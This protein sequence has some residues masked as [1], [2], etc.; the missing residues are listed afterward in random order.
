MASRSRKG[1][2]EVAPLFLKPTWQVENATSSRSQTEYRE[3]DQFAERQG[4][5]RFQFLFRLL[6]IRKVEC[7]TMQSMQ[8]GQ[9]LHRELSTI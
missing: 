8:D 4:A 2:G 3:E 9:V 7:P 1:N 6:R 5:L